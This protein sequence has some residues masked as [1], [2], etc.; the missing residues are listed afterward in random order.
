[1]VIGSGQLAQIFKTGDWNDVCIFASGVSNSSCSDPLEFEREKQLLLVS[2][3]KN[4]HKKFVYF[5]SCALSAPSYP[6]KDYYLHKQKMENLV[7]QISEKYYIFRLPQLFGDLVLHKTLIN[8][9]YNAIQRDHD[10]DVYNQAYRYVIEIED[11]KT[12]VEAFLKFSDACLT[13][14]IANPYR[15]SA[16]RIVQIFEELLSKKVKYT[17][18]NKYDQYELDLTQMKAFVNKNNLFIEFGEDYLMN[19]LKLKLSK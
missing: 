8:F 17:I 14:D 11:V 1:M 19:K 6:K 3:E 16:I 4:I 9:I 15:Y 7:K 5:S 12:L 10:F 2:L 13:I 18:I